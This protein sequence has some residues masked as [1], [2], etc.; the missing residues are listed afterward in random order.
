MGVAN[1][2]LTLGGVKS[3]LNKNPYSFRHLLWRSLLPS[4]A[5]FISACLLAFGLIGL[6]L[7]LLSADAGQILPKL[8]DPFGHDWNINESHFLHPVASFV[9]SDTVNTVLA[10]ALRLLILWVAY[11]VIKSIVSGMRELRS[12][13]HAVYVPAENQIVHHPLEHDMLIR[14]VWRV[15]ILTLALTAAALLQPLLDHVWNWDQQL[16]HST[17]YAHLCRLLAQAFFSWLLIFQV[18]VVLLRLFLFRTRV[19][20]EVVR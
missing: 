4:T 19:Y 15:S 18:Y 8:V 13:H 6:H 7:L 10:V 1:D 20:G 12:E 9:H 5:S 2:Y 11:K 16:A 17:D 14:F 3:M